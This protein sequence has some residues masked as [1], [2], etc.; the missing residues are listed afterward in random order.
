MGLGSN[1]CD[2]LNGLITVLNPSL[3]WYVGKICKLPG[4]Q[5]PCFIERG[6]SGQVYDF[7]NKTHA[8]EYNHSHNQQKHHA[9]GRNHHGK[10]S[11]Y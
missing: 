11:N 5:M 3:L 2:N 9:Y 7:C 8:E 6:R 1:N 4:C 10:E